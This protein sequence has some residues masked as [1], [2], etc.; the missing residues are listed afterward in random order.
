M[1]F[2]VKNVDIKLEALKRNNGSGIYNKLHH[3]EHNLIEEGH[4]N[5]IIEDTTTKTLHQG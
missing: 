1:I 4:N 5:H 3:R 2:L